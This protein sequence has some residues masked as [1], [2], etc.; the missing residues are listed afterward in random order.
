SSSGDSSERPLHSSL[1][2]AGPSRKRCRSSVDS[3]PSSTPVIGSLA[4]TRADL[5]P[6]RR[7]FRD[8]YSSE[9]NM[10]E[11]TEINT[12]ETKDGRE[13]DI[14][15]RD[16]ARNRVKIDPKDVKDDTE[17]YEADISVGDTVEVGIDLMSAPIADEESEEPDGE[18]SS[19]SSNTRD[20]IVRSFEDMP[21]DL[22][23]VVRDFYHHMS[24]IRDDRNDLR[25][26]L[27]RLESLAERRL[28]CRP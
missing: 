19:Y 28:G 21:I 23:D 15:D 9:N 20:G 1:H 5:F 16:D 13:L 6:P 7:R 26:R 27:R 4:P 22:D 8:S 24:E 2:S 14:C 3:V 25:R 17:E 12:I 11:D 10:E 18:D